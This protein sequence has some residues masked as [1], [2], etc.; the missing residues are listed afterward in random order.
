MAAGEKM[1][2]FVSQ[3][4]GEQREG[5]GE[6]GSQGERVAIDEGEGAKE[7]IPGDGFIVGVGGG[8]MRACDQTRAEGGNEEEAGEEQ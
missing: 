7:F 1:A 5:E 4:N 2:E 8:K 3:E 6:S